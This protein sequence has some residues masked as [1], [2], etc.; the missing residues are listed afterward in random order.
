M[1]KVGQSIFQIKVNNPIESTPLF[2]VTELK[3]SKITQG[4]FFNYELSKQDG[5]VVTVVNEIQLDVKPHDM[6]DVAFKKDFYTDSFSNIE[7]MLQKIWTL[8]QQKMSFYKKGL[9]REIEALNLK[10]D[11]YLE[12]KNI[13]K[14]DIL[15]QV[16]YL[17]SNPNDVFGEG[18][19]FIQF[20][21]KTVLGE[22]TKFNLIPTTINFL[23]ED[24]MNRVLSDSTEFDTDMDIDDLHELIEEALEIEGAE[25]ATV[26]DYE[27]YTGDVIDQE[28]FILPK[29]QNMLTV[30]NDYNKGYYAFS[31]THYV[32]FSSVQEDSS[33]FDRS[34]S[35]FLEEVRSYMRD[36][37]IHFNEI[38]SRLSG[39]FSYAVV[40]QFYFE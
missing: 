37:S 20:H 5:T 38:Q 21:Y 17:E 7:P 24:G 1:H 19:T 28:T 23:D 30:H 35:E 40:D 25:I 18:D 14:E 29:G 9:L 33:K 36:H 27:E 26:Y 12:S 4:A 15:E 22:P 10:S 13:S 31:H 11:E 6:F 8:L 16:G 32:S 34:I 2:S 3:V 39:E